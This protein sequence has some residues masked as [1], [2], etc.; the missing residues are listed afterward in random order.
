MKTILVTYAVREEYIP[1]QV[2][3]A[4]VH[5]VRTGVGKTRSAALLTKSIC[6]QKPDFVLNIGTAGT[7][8]HNVGDVFVSRCFIDRDYEA[9]KLPG[10]EYK[11]EGDILLPDNHPLKD[12]IQRYDKPGICNT[13]DT[14]I[15]ELSSFSADVVDME[16]FAQAFVC[17]E[18][19]VPFL[20]VKY[21]TDIIGQ[22]SVAHWEEKLSDARLG[23]TEWFEKHPILSLIIAG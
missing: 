17:R 15:T 19:N 3:G 13:G 23:L 9:T 10:L 20:S 5:Y 4:N 7:V 18:F 14:F 6:E 2:D 1:L 22:N 12:W 11:I 21:V 8:Q 16:A